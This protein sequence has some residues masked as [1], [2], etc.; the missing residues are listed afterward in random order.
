MVDL[1]KASD[2]KLDASMREIKANIKGINVHLDDL[3]T[4]KR[5]VDSQLGHLA[6]AIPRASGN[7]SGKTEENPRAHIAA[8]T[9]RSG[10]EMQP[11]QVDGSR[12]GDSSQA[13][14][15]DS[16]SADG[17]YSSQAMGAIISGSSRRL[18]T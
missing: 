10:R 13:G 11:S 8:V 6:S 12:S 1:H 7:L 5:G 9:L 2:Q 15:G 3:E 4:W 18:A 16:S 14:A 17:G